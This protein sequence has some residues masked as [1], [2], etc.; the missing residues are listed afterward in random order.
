MR[1]MAK[2]RYKRMVG[3]DGGGV[4]PRKLAFFLAEIGVWVSLRVCERGKEGLRGESVLNRLNLDG[5]VRGRG[6]REGKGNKKGRYAQYPP[7]FFKMK[8]W[9]YEP[10]CNQSV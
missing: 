5:E 1:E 2:K 7:S 4:L 8:L 10:H 3:V 6:K 9:I